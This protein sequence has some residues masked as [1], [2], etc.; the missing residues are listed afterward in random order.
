MFLFCDAFCWLL[1][2]FALTFV[3]KLVCFCYLRFVGFRIVLVLFAYEMR[4]V[5]CFVAWLGMFLV[6]LL[7]VVFLLLC[8][9]FTYLLLV[10]GFTSW[11]FWTFLLTWLSCWGLYL[12]SV[13]ISL[14]FILICFILICCF[15]WFV[16]LITWLVF[17]FDYFLGLFRTVRFF[18]FICVFI[19]LIDYLVLTELL[20]FDVVGFSGAVVWI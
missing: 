5:A 19:I 17:C 1:A 14:C 13:V 8:L 7:G 3:I 12:F 16:V 9:N 4:F 15:G 2:G 10:V 11:W 20:C 6:I 18:L